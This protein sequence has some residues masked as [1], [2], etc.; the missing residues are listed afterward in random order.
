MK[1]TTFLFIILFSLII[2]QSNAQN[3]VE[4]KLP[5]KANSNNLEEGKLCSFKFEI[6]KQ[7][8]SAERF[9]FEIIQGKV[10]GM[11]MDSS[12]HFEWTPSYND[13]DRIEKE[14]V[15]QLLI[16]ARSDSG[17]VATKAIDLRVS[18]VNRP[19][20]VSE[21]KPFYIKYNTSNTYRIDNAVVYDADNDPVVVIPSI[22]ELPE[23]FSISSQGEMTWSPSFTQFKSLKESPKYIRF[24]VQDQPY[25][26]Q[27]EGRVKLVATQ[28]DL[29]PAITIVPKNRRI[30]IRE[31]ETVNIRFY[32]SDPNGDDDIETFEYLTNQKTL[33][34]NLLIR[35]TPNQYEFTWMPGYDFVKDPLDSLSFYIDFFVLDKTQ[36]REVIRVD[37]RVNNTLNREEEDAK[38]FNLYRGTVLRAWELMEQ[39][40]EKEDEL[41]SAYNRAKKGKKQRSVLNAGLGAVTG[42]SSVITRGKNDLQ[43]S[44]STIGGTTVLTIGTLEATEVIGRSTKDL[45]DRLNYIIE[46]KNDI[47]TKGDIFARDYSLKS[48]RRNDK[49]TRDMDDFMKLMQLK[50]LVA[51]ELDASWSPKIKSTDKAI[52]RTFKDYTNE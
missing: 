29:P 13:V 28:L 18:H 48:A 51:L 3:S 45:I 26:A 30:E 46:K 15:F 19:P 37:L 5:Q 16:S 14:R 10:I 35:N 23:G 34:G 40:K 33:P 39:L 41:K 22:E 49:F 7:H 20:V 52:K 4:I 44:I 11:E 24:Y 42:L 31:N 25:K 2:I 27:T 50:G 38:Q 32:L 12:G 36:K 17:K 6:K 1:N 21:V 8:E 43:R 47:Q 9:T